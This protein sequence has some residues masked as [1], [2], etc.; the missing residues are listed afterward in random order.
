MIKTKY[1]R[2]SNAIVKLRNDFGIELDSPKTNFKTE[3]KYSGDLHE[4]LEYRKKHG[5]EL[6]L[7]VKSW[8]V[9]A[10]AQAVLIKDLYE[11]PKSEAPTEAQVDPA[12]AAQIKALTD[13][14]V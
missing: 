12:L 1:G 2:L 3:E 6:E 9:R 7:Q 14:V 4:A 5:K 10:L 11:N 13:S 8:E